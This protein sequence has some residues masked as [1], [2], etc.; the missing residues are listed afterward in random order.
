M[1][2]DRRW[3]AIMVG[4]MFACFGA[5][6]VVGRR[7]PIVI[8]GQRTPFARRCEWHLGNQP[9]RLAGIGGGNCRASRVARACAGGHHAKDV[10]DIGGGAAE[11]MNATEL[12][13]VCR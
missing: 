3:F 8:E 13:A 12:Q 10:H 4:K 7:S 1:K 6:I 5:T 11:W 2:D 9:A